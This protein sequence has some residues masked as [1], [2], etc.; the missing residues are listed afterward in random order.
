MKKLFLLA[1]FI[2]TNSIMYSDTP[3]S[4]FVIA[5]ATGGYKDTKYLNSVESFENSYK[6]GA[7]LIE[8]DFVMTLDNKVVA[9]HGGSFFEKLMGMPSGFTYAD[10]TNTSKY[11]APFNVQ[12]IDLPILVK[13]LKKYPD[14]YI[15]T[16]HKRNQAVM[17][18]IIKAFQ[19]NNIPLK[20]LIPQLYSF[21]D[22]E[23]Y[24]AYIEIKYKILT[25][26]A[27]IEYPYK[28]WRKSHKIEQKLPFLRVFKEQ[29]F[30]YKVKEFLQQNKDVNI[31]TI[32]VAVF[33]EGYLNS[34]SE[35][36]NIPI[37]VHPVDTIEHVSKLKKMGVGGIYS[38]FLTEKE[39]ATI[40]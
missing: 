35:E 1:I 17:G 39:L 20:Q 5:H 19:D 28:L 23:Y 16:D 14:V 18:E 21:E 26:Y 36:L 11:P 8:I 33:E 15:V 34:L 3:L 13:L 25:L 6:N 32:P 7:R 22:I 29:Y 4:S 10:W 12:K 30:K 2:G 38:S 37:Y 9:F 24:K 40:D 31:L 27:I